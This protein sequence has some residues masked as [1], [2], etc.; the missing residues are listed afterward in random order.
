[1][2]DLHTELL[3]VLLD[4]ILSFKHDEEIVD[5][6]F[7]TILIDV[8]SSVLSKDYEHAFEIIETAEKGGYG[9]FGD[10]P[11]LLDKCI[12]SH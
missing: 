3:E 1:M 4:H 10:L 7:H 8:V 6:Q 5:P 9:G 11:N 12:P 2:N